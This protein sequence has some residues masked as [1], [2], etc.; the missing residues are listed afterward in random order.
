MSWHIHLAHHIAH[1]SP[2][3]TN[4]WDAQDGY[5]IENIN[6]L[7]ASD[8][9]RTDGSGASGN[10]VIEFDRGHTNGAGITSALILNNNMTGPGHAWTIEAADNSGFSTN[11]TT[12]VNSDT[13]KTQD[14][15]F[16]LSSNTQRYVRLEWERT[17]GNGFQIGCFSLGVS[18][19]VAGQGPLIATER[20]GHSILRTFRKVTRANAELIMDEYSRRYIPS[21]VG[22]SGA[23]DG[24]GGWGGQNFTALIDDSTSPDTVWFGRS[25]LSVR[26]FAA[27]YSEVVVDMDLDR[28]G[29]LEG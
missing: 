5:P 13:T 3:I 18:Y 20:L 15:W 17:S 7:D 1:L 12:L 23:I 29:V 10:M 24:I 4:S 27:N 19:Q 21:S 14:I 2:T 8:A 16:P 22:S 9:Y 28:Q 11:L 26:G 25:R 6:T